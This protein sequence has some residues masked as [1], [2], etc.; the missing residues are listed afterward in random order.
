VRGACSRRSA[1]TAEPEHP[2]QLCRFDSDRLGVVDDGR[3]RDVTSVLEYLPPCR[4]PAPPGDQLIANLRRL[5]PRITALLPNAAILALERARLQAP[6]ANPGKVIAVRSNYPGAAST[7]DLDPQLFL[8]ASSSV[9]GPCIGIELRLP[10][11]RVD[12]EVELAAIIGARLDRA[13]PG[14]ALAAVAGYCIGID[15]T[16]RGDEDRGLRKS[17]DGF[18]VLG[19]WLTTADQATGVADAAIELAVNGTL[20]QSGRTAQM[21][22]G[23]AGLIAA[24]SRYFVLEPGDVVMTGTPQGVGPLAAGDQIFCSIEGLGTMHVAVR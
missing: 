22:V 14:Q 12:H 13:P 10:G 8:K 18:T 3:I 17:L 7:A 19:P 2:L 4:W 1:S 23:V 9:A 24:A 15:V 5:R 11:R 6:V 16:L 20:R 21:S